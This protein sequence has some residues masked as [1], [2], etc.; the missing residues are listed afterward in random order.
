MQITCQSLGNIN[1]LLE[2]QLEDEMET[3][4]IFGNEGIIANIVI[5]E[6]SSY[7]HSIGYLK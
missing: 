2:N 5:A 7:N 6:S 3:G 4:L 1:F